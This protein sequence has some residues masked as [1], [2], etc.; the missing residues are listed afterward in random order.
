ME[1][2]NLIPNKST[3]TVMSLN[4]QSI[5]AKFNKFEMFINY[6][7]NHNCN[8]DI[9]NLQESWLSASSYYNDIIL[10]GYELYIQ[11]YIYTPTWWL[12]YLH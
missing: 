1:I 7:T 4:C 2:I 11:P 8:A 6:L 10:P 9:I 3:F 12:N 5:S